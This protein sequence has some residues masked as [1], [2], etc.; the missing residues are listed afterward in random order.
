MAVA[1]LFLQFWVRHVVFRLDNSKLL[2]HVTSPFWNSELYLTVK[3]I[4]TDKNALRKFKKNQDDTTIVV[5]YFNHKKKIK[6]YFLRQKSNL[7]YM[8]SCSLSPL[9]RETWCKAAQV[10]F[11][12]T[13]MISQDGVGRVIENVFVVHNQPT[14]LTTPYHNYFRL[15]AGEIAVC[16]KYLL[17][18]GP[19]AHVNVRWVQ[20]QPCNSRPGR[21]R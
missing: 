19:R 3:N 17:C 20:Q 18:K 9:I 1:P 14:S 2:R 11:H 7:I 8:K 15:R 21:L 5:F 4:K 12:L 6:Q 16:L 13:K 10:I